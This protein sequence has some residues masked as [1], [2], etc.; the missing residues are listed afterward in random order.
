MPPCMDIQETRESLG[1]VGQKGVLALVIGLLLVAKEN[2]KAGIGA[3]LIV[4][5]MGL[6]ARGLVQSALEEMG[7][8]GM[9]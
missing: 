3:A 4:I 2:K 5:G 8:G 1:D 6:V 9:L 7:M